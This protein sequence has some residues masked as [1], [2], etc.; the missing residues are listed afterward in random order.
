MRAF[1]IPKPA[2]HGGNNCT[3]M[4]IRGYS[5]FHSPFNGS[6]VPD[7]IV[8]GMPERVEVLLVFGYQLTHSDLFGAREPAVKERGIVGRLWDSLWIQPL[9]YAYGL[10]SSSDTIFTFVTR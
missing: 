6:V 4:S 5:N 2:M 9:K 7:M 3:L 10:H 1:P 8:F